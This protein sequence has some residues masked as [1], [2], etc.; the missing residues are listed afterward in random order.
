MFYFSI[1]LY[2]ILLFL[3]DALLSHSIERGFALVFGS[4]FGGGDQFYF[5]FPIVKIELTIHYS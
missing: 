4:Y 2:K 5:G 3:Y 1:I